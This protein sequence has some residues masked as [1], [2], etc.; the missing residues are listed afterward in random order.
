MTAMTIAYLAPEIPARSATFVYQEV[1]ELQRQ[2][3]AV[4]CYSL[5]RPHDPAPDQR[6]LQRETCYLYSGGYFQVVWRAIKALSGFSL[7]YR[8][9]FSQL[10]VDLKKVTGWRTRLKLCYQF[11]A[12][13]YLAESLQRNQVTHLHVHFA[14][15]PTQVAMYASALSGIPFTVTSHA[16]DIFERG[17]LLPEKAQRSVGFFTISQFNLDYLKSQGV[18]ESKLGIVRCG[19]SLEYQN[20]KP[21]LLQP[22]SSVVIGTLGRLVEKKGMDVLISAFA[23]L[24]EARPDLQLSLRIAG[25][26][27]LRDTLQQMIQTLNIEQAVHFEGALPHSAVRG[28]LET[29][30][31]FVLACKVDANGD[32]DGIPVVL[33]EA[34]SQSVP[35]VTTRLSGMPELVIPATTG[36][37]AEPGDVDSL[38]KALLHVLDQRQQLEVITAQALQHV[39]SEFSLESNVKRLTDT[40]KQSAISGEN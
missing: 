19:V 2:G 5:H 26:G 18:P 27:P 25:D 23:K 12:A 40:F 39:M 29:L 1:H 6:I 3:Y 17:L 4:L 35:V 14:H 8:N 28:W 7:Q 30:D 13:L 22:K 20:A 21:K 15:V 10:A 9:G 24:Q 36:F 34:M 38:V 33:M 37:L 16:N 32:M 31:L 11:L